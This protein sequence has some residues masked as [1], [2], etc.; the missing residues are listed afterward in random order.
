MVAQFEQFAEY[1]HSA[2]VFPLDGFKLIVC[3]PHVT[4]AAAIGRCQTVL[5]ASRP[6]GGP[7]VR[8]L[9]G[10]RATSPQLGKPRAAKAPKHRTNAERVCLVEPARPTFC[11]VQHHWAPLDGVSQQMTLT[12]LTCG[13]SI[14]AWQQSTVDTLVGEKVSAFTS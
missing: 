6:S 5:F 14:S 4:A 10:F 12:R 1:D 3:A 11:P 2:G 9:E 7:F 13:A 8:S